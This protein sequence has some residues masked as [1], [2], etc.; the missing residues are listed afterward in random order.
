MKHAEVV[1]A[2][3]AVEEGRGLV[4]IVNK[5]DLLRG[6]QNAKL[7]EK[8]LKAVPQEIQ[9]VIPQITGIP[10]VFVSALE[11]KGQI[12]IMR[13][14]VDTYEKW[15]LRLSTA[16]LNRWLRKV[17]SRHSWKDQAAQPRIKYFTQ[18]KAR[19][20]TFV[21]FVSGKTHLADTDIRFL[22]K[23]LKED[24]GMGGIPVRIVQRS[25][26]RKEGSGNFAK[27]N[28]TSRTPLRVGSDKRNA[29]AAL[30][31]ACLCR[32]PPREV[33]DS[34][35]YGINS[36]KKV[37]CVCFGAAELQRPPSLAFKP[38]QIRH[39]L[40]QADGMLSTILCASR[41]NGRQSSAKKQEGHPQNADL[42]PILPKK[43]KK[44][45]PI[46]LKNLH[47]M[48]RADK[49]LAE[50]GIEKPL[51]APKNGLLVPDLV[52]VAYKV[53]VAW[54]VLIKGLAQLLTVVPV[55]GCSECAEVHVGQTGHQIQDCQGTT[56]VQ[57]RSFH[58]WVKGSIN[59][60]LVP[61]E[62]YHLYDP[63]G[64]RIKH[65]TRFNYDRIPALVELCI[66]AG[67]DLPEYPSRRRTT[68]VRMIGKKVIDRGGFVEEPKPC[69]SGDSSSLLAE[70]DTYAAHLV[71]SPHPSDVPQ[72]AEETL[73]AYETVM[74]GVRKLMR[75]YTV[76]ACGYCSEVHVGPWGHNVKLCGE[77]KHQWR[78][79]KH[80]WQDATVEEVVPPNYVWHV[81]DP[82][83]P[84]LRGPLKRFYGKAPAVVEVCVQ[85]GAAIPEKYRPM[86]RLDIIVPDCEEA[87]LVA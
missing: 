43:K 3:Q 51:E 24:F 19:P 6:K 18:V 20:P 47:R 64:R 58:S 83:G 39:R 87:R 21:A 48:A 1:I 71:Q 80:G 17:M 86:M 8:V 30:S 50:K 76:K 31:Q 33:G 82:N 25:V 23:S 68:A 57:R 12:F 67:V 54:K 16:C 5:I 75:K 26:P 59:D 28:S 65:E 69:R 13:Q 81:R 41:E 29:D 73:E 38:L 70:L 63:F 44:P 32:P 11:G 37:T 60:V 42:P 36:C 55:Y 61:I 84:P 14:V 72:L 34:N 66:Q 56:N 78:D 45:Y 27:K 74:W 85:A 46:P 49:K 53:L 15:C 4:V 10:V 77:F 62:S 79:G 2:R 35:Y 40:P 9:T 7:Y 22:T 52:P